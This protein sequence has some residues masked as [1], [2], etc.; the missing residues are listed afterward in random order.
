MEGV[1]G[2]DPQRLARHKEKKV[3]LGY[4]RAARREGTGSEVKAIRITKIS[5]EGVWVWM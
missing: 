1:T 5:E 2:Q 3:R 4:L